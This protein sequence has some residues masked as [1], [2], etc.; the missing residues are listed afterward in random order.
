MR[1][2]FTFILIIT[3]TLTFCTSCSSMGTKN[4]ELQPL[5][6]GL[7]SDLNSIPFIIAKQQGYLGDNVTI[8][9]FKSSVDRDSALFSGNLDGTVS[10]L[11]AVALAQNGDFEAYATSTTNGRYGIAATAA[12]GIKTA[13]DLEGKEIGLSLNTI[14]EYFADRAVTLDGGSPE[15]VEKV[16]VP[17]MPTR[18]ELLENNQ[19]D[20]IGAPDPF[21]TAAASGG[22]TVVCTSDELNINPS[23]MFFTGSA[24]KEKNKELAA[25]YVAY[26]K[27]AEYIN[28]GDPAEFMPRVIEELG[29]PESAI[30]VVLPVYEKN[31]PV[32]KEE[33][34]QAVE[35]LTAH[36]LIEKNFEYD[37]LVRKIK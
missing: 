21:V 14:I 1:K 35:W 17:K 28:N 26:D 4:A 2:T 27:A 36:G 10:D 32:E 15:K 11:L 33:V 31:T 3:L 18:L 23:C 13:K 20:A 19:I 6:L 37:D 22:A 25:L 34:E 30:D 29:L 8:E 7:M 5:T 24:V 12:S 9:I 16:A